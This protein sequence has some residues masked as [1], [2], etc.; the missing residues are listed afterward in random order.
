MD[1]RKSFVAVHAGAGYHS[2]SKE[3]EYRSVCKDACKQAMEILRNEGTSLAAVTKAVS[4]LE[5][6]P[7]TNAGL[8]SNLTQDGIVECD[9]SVMD[10]LTLTSGAVGCIT[11][12]QNP[13][14]VAKQLV[15]KQV[16]GGLS[17]GRIPPSI[18]VGPGARQ[19]A[20]EQGITLT[21]EGGLVTESSRRTYLKY[22]RKLDHQTA[23]MEKR[24]TADDTVHK[25]MK[26]GKDDLECGE[27]SGVQDTVGCVC[28]DGDGNMAAACSSGG[29]WMKH[30]GRMGPAAH[31]GVGSWAHNGCCDGKPG[32]AVVSSGGG[33]HLIKTFLAKTCADSVQ[34]EPNASLAVSST[35]KDNFLESEFLSG[36]EDKHGGV[37][38]LKHLMED[39]GFREAEVLWAHTTDSMC[40]GYML[41]THSKPTTF[42]SRLP[43][44]SL[45]GK[46]FAM[47]GRI[48]NFDQ[49]S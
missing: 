1:K 33:E 48:L 32:V 21:A 8:G 5:D 4:V 31:Y 2:T 45:P 35:F 43:E 17:L 7:L 44:S 36:V 30:R 9:A 40:I 20:E 10:G 14:L 34:K 49:S 16:Q 39:D 24:Q 15:Q 27:S 42:V 28:V 11:D 3:T 46:S 13:V 26:T 22:K 23:L 41:E 25:K 19:W 18:L 6:S 37:L 38:V 47:E 12:V 29:I